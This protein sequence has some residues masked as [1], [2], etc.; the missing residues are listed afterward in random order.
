L[1]AACKSLN[2]PAIRATASDPLPSKSVTVP[3]VAANP[4]EGLKE[5][6][7]SKGVLPTSEGTPFG[8]LYVTKDLDNIYLGLIAMD[9]MDESLYIGK[10]IP[11]IDRNRWQIKIAGLPKTID[12]RYGGKGQKASVNMSGIEVHEISGLKYVV[13]IKIPR[14]MIK[15]TE[16]VALWSS[17]D[18]HGRSAH[19]EWKVDLNGVK[20]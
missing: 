8:D 16:P 2:L 7:R 4:F 13:M 18:T 17:A 10:H 3:F 14:S 9:Y 20:K 19:M 15:A 11:E 12:I 5:W 1:T 6:P